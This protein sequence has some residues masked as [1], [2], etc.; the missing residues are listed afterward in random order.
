MNT[1]NILLGTTSLL[2]VVAFAVSFGGFKS[3]KDSDESQ[4]LRQQLQA[5]IAKAEAETEALRLEQLRASASY[6][7]CNRLQ[8]SLQHLLPRHPATQN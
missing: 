6:P 4:L 7:S 8:L 2:L 1:T 3:N 5:E